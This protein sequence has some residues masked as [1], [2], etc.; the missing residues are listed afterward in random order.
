[1]AAVGSSDAS[2][3]ERCLDIKRKV[4]RDLGLNR[5]ALTLRRCSLAASGADAIGD[6][7]C[8]CRA[9]RVRVVPGDQGRS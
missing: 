7:G 8:L 6:G 2:G 1:M 3:R 4:N 5:S 9:G